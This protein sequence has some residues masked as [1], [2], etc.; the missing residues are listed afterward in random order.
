MSPIAGIQRQLE[1]L[2]QRVDELE[3]QLQGAQADNI[4]P[5]Y[6]GINAQG[7]VIANL[8][9]VQLPVYDYVSTN[10]GGP[11]PDS[12]VKWVNAGGAQQGALIASRATDT[13]QNF[14]QMAA[15]AQAPGELSQA[16]IQA[17]DDLD[18]LQASL[19]TTQ[20]NRGATASVNAQ[21]GNTV[22][23]IA[24]QAGNS[25]F[26][27]QAGG[28][29]ELTFAAGTYNLPGNNSST[30]EVVINHGLGR[31]PVAWAASID[32]FATM[33]A[34][35]DLEPETMTVILWTF[36]IPVGAGQPV[37]T[38]EFI[39]GDAYPLRWWALG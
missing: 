12:F 10:P 9:G 33:A 15:F 32:R 26:L 6:L 19:N 22:Y 11:A 1:Q 36:T 37:T 27:K 5:N 7:R 8:P 31:I 30:V 16:N 24:D 35:T 28:P 38:G 29:G 34:T 23:T 17:R 25:S 21:V 20:E 2:Q 3:Q 4:A 18:Q 39:S 14:T 13:G